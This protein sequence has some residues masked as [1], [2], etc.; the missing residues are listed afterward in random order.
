GA[1][2]FNAYTAHNGT[3]H[4]IF[5][6][7]DNN[8][9]ADPNTGFDLL[10]YT[11]IRL[12]NPNTNVRIN[13]DEVNSQWGND[14]VTVGPAV[15]GHELGHACNLEHHGGSTTRACIMWSVFKV[16][17]PIYHNYCTSNPGDIH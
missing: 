2:N 8:L 17:E 13:V 4:G 3:Q 10:G 1:M 15:I 7:V 5:L 9:P 12:N 6:M 11:E 14:A 16:G